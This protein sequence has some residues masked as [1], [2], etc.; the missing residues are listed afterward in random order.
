[1]AICKLTL[2]SIAFQLNAFFKLQNFQIKWKGP[3]YVIYFFLGS[4][5]L[6]APDFNYCKKVIVS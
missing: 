3:T 4:G 2:L 1:M 5:A 6:K